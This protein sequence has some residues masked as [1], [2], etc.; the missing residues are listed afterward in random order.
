MEQIQAKSLFNRATG[1]IARGGFDFTVN[2]YVGCTFGCSYCYAAFLPQNPHPVEDWGRWLVA[3]VNAIALARKMAPKMLGKAIFCS[4]VTDPY[5]PAERSLM[6]TRGI[7]EELL[8]FQPRLVIQTRGP[9][10]VRDLDVLAQFKRLRVHVSIPTDCDEVRAAFEPKAPPLA[11]R[12]DALEVLAAEGIAL[13]VTITPTLPVRDPAAFARR[14]AALNP[15]RVV[16]QMFH[17]AQG[18]GADT[19]PEVRARLEEWD[20]T[21]ARY[22]A[23]RETLQAALPLPVA[24]GEAGF[25]PPA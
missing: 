7:L 17:V 1:F 16:T 22:A 13:G 18:F 12:W 4:S 19:T 25:D 2:P 5:L 24:E 20:W 8:P 23:L 21:S 11:R 6:L 3:K 14:I 15:Q 9:L 10:I